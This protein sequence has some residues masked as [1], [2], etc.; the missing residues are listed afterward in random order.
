[1][2]TVVMT[3]SSHTLE[4]DGEPVTTVQLRFRLLVAVLLTGMLA[5]L[6]PA[7]AAA[8]LPDPLTRGPYT[9]TTMS[10]SD[11]A[12]AGAPGDVGEAK[13]GLA[14]LEEPN[15]TGGAV[16]TGTP[17]AAANAVQLQVR[18]SLYYPADRSAPSPLIVLVHG[19]HGSC[20]QSAGTGLGGS[21]AVY[22]RNDAGYAY[23]AANL[24]SWGY[25]VFSLDQDQLIFYQDG[26]YGKG[27]HQRRLLIAAA[28]D[29]LYQADQPGG[30]PVDANDNV[31]TQ[32]VGKLDFSRIGLMGHSRGGDAV[33]SFLDYNRTRPAPGR[34]YNIRAVISL[35]P[36]D[37]ERRAPYG[38]VY[39]TAFGACDGDVSDV[40]GARLFERSLYVQPNDPFPRIQMV[41]HGANHD[42]FNTEWDADGDDASSAD[43][44]CGVNT[45]TNPDT[46]RL[47]RG[48]NVMNGAAMGTDYTRTNFFLDTPSLMGDQA[49]AGLAMMAEF[50]RRYVGGETPFDDYM[51]GVVSQD[52]VTPQL[53]ASACPTS[54]PGM[55]MACNQRLLTTYFAPPQER[56]NVIRPNPD[57]PLTVSELGTGLTGSGFAPPYANSAGTVTPPA[58]AGGYDWC[59]PEPNQFT[60]SQL[61]ITP[62]L[63]TAV[64]PCPLPGANALGG[65]SNGARENAPVT[66]SYGLQL[67]LAWDHPATPA[68]LETRIPAASGDVT[69]Y[70][71]LA[72]DAAVNYFDPRNPVRTAQAL[73][74]PSA[75]T[76]NFTVSVTDANGVRGTVQAG[77]PRY[78]LALHQ[79]IGSTTTRVHII[80]NQIRIPVAD[81][82]AQGVDLHSLR[83]IQLGFGDTSIAG[84]PA[85]GS[86]ELADV[87]FQEAVSGPTV[88][89]DSATANGPGTAP[90]LVGGDPS[91]PLVAAGLDPA[92]EAAPSGPDSAAII[93]ATPRAAASAALPDVVWADGGASAA[94]SARCTDT[95]APVATIA[96]KR[97]VKGRLVLSGSASDKGCATSAVRSVDVVI[98]AHVAGKRTC[99]L[100][101]AS[102]KLGKAASC[103]IPPP[104][105][106][107]AAGTKKWSL[108]LTGKLAKGSYTAY[109]RA[110]DAAGNEQAIG[111][112]L[113]LKIR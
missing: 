78:G 105:T 4:I 52:G 48:G 13:V 37:Y 9:V 84:M 109:V 24:A 7:V 94:T 53:P 107:V 15:G 89:A 20:N 47:G 35:A 59:N 56:L 65:Q 80:L 97:L 66:R 81:F 99:K 23:L 19:N 90:A 22:N 92:P 8:A 72:M 74:D 82:A 68:H 18:G 29:G 25:V 57:Q 12:H 28:L 17:N 54:A 100:V 44:A 51:T 111:R 50:F 30:L 34:R 98:Y 46:I 2:S 33:A 26:N 103:S 40:M 39:A 108:R 69:K 106:L 79:T 41:L 67:T 75:T 73:W 11:P 64:K 38:V 27:M 104:A 10:V 16:G 86:I 61:G 36:T 5:A 55:H 1:M 76:Q 70:K 83:S 101:R 43:A 91:D 60:P 110:I 113:T 14:N 3:P 96:G 32:L 31:G 112:R 21:C 87:R 49:R 88:Y 42:A 45:T 93:D 62:T 85:S 77:D 95:T 102:G 63:P 71:A 58:T 6:T